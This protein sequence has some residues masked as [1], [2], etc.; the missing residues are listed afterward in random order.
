VRDRVKPL[1]MCVGRTG[2]V[3]KY[4]ETIYGEHL[5]SKVAG[6]FYKGKGRY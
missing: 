5:L 6:N 2:G 3:P 1:P 4:E